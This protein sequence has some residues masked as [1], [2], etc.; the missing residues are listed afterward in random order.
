MKKCLEC[1]VYVD[2][3]RKTCPL[4]GSVLEGNENE[5]TSVGYPKYQQ[6]P[7]KKNYVLRTFVFLTITGILVCALINFL[8]YSETP[9]LWAAYPIIGSIYMW[10]LIR[11]TIISR[12]NASF[13]LLIQMITLSLVVYGIDYFTKNEGWA[14]NYV[15]PFLSIA[16]TLMIA[17][18]LMARKMKFGEYIFNLFASIILGFIPFILWITKV[19]TVSWPSFTA[20]VVSIVTLIGMIIFADKEIKEEFKKRFNI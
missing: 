9:V 19:C 7:K 20:A 8:T 12:K 15:V 6:L 2:T 13:K 16:S 5:S 14:L 3:E 1:K 4:C 11:F 17:I 10:I 18:I